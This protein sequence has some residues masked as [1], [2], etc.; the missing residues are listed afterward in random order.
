LVF[1][2]NNQVQSTPIPTGTDKAGA[3]S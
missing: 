1:A 2:I 3:D